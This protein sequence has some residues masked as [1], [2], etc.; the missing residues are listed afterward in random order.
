MTFMAYESAIL[1]I[2]KIMPS[3][4]Q[5]QLLESRLCVPF[6]LVTNQEV[7][8]GLLEPHC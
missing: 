6:F 4:H 8:F 1:G 2:P 3:K 7:D 5:S